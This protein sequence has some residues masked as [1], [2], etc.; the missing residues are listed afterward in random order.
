[1]LPAAA[2]AVLGLVGRSFRAFET[3]W[4]YIGDDFDN[5]LMAADSLAAY[6]HLSDE[7]AS[8]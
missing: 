7:A 6:V 4:R 1:M 3:R 2:V 8:D 5:A